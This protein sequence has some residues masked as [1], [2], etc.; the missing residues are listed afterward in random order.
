MVAG[1]TN[2]E[3]VLS[4]P[5]HCTKHHQAAIHS[6][7][8][9]RRDIAVDY[10]TTS[11]S[12]NGTLCQ[13]FLQCRGRVSNFTTRP[14]GRGHHDGRGSYSSIV[15]SSH[16]YCCSC[17]LNVPPDTGPDLIRCKS[18]I[19]APCHLVLTITPSP[20]PPGPPSAA[21]LVIL[22]NGIY[23][24]PHDLAPDLTRHNKPTSLAN[25]IASRVPNDLDIRSSITPFSPNLL[26][27]PPPSYQ[28]SIRRLGS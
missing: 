22:C 12:S 16:S 13:A 5:S 9:P 8:F 27:L 14:Q 1:P 3:L 6:A 24:L 17:P 18:N 23:F 2:A 21:T 20:P 7:F 10:W 11:L 28:S 26:H 15:T 4:S 25:L 19:I